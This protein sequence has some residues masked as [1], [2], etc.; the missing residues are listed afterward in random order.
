MQ[1]ASWTQACP[2]PDT[3]P[4]WDRGALQPHLAR[5][6]TLFMPLVAGTPALPPP[7]ETA[8]PVPEGCG[9]LPVPCGACKWLAKS[10]SDILAT[11]PA[12]ER[13]PTTRSQ[14]PGRGAHAHA[15]GTPPLPRVR[16]AEG[17]PSPPASPVVG[18]RSRPP[19][20]QGPPLAHTPS[21][22]CRRADRPRAARRAG[23]PRSGTGSGRGRGQCPGSGKRGGP[24]DGGS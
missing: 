7:W 17:W 6:L 16:P 9:P 21:A 12:G 4:S 23:T 13:A 1:P 3:L 20:W 19:G 18:Q 2:S 5:P 8:L 11:S 14:A 24:G 15:G 10:A 22:R